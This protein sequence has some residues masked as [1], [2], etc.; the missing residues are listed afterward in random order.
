MPEGKAKNIIAKFFAEFRNEW[1][2]FALGAFE[3][4]IFVLFG[5]TQPQI[6][7]ET[8]SFWIFP[9]RVILAVFILTAL[10]IFILI[11]GI[12]AYNRW[13]IKKAQSKL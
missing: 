6:L 9:W 1:Q 2:N 10:V 7:Q 11:K 5:Q 8:I 3:A 13:I 12:K 4:D